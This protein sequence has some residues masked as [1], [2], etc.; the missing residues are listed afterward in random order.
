MLSDKNDRNVIIIDIHVF[1]LQLSKRYFPITIITT[2]ESNAF[3][4]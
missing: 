4:L 2:F 3:R 1:C